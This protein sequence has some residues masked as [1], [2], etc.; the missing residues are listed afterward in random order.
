MTISTETKEMSGG[1][2]AGRKVVYLYCFADAARLK[3][4]EGTGIEGKNPL[5]LKQSNGIAAVCSMEKV[6][7]FMGPKGESNLLDIQ[8]V[9]SRACRHQ[10]VIEMAMKKSPVFPARFGTLFSSEKSMNHVLEVHHDTII[11]FL[12]K[13]ADKQ[14]W[15]I[16]GYLDLDNLI[17]EI[18]TELILN[19]EE[20]SEGLSQGKRY[21]RQKQKQAEARLKLEEWIKES[22]LSI[23]GSL[24]AIAA[25]LSEREIISRKASGKDLDMVLNW[26]ALIQENAVQTFWAE[27]DRI[28]AHKRFKGLSLELSGPWPPYSF[29]PRLDMM[30]LA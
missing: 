26:A 9:G 7:D 21:L 8:W 15:S 2:D 10:A 29:R 18:T 4:I 23:A 3:A 17:E 22:R 6:S 5:T 24:E 12:I 1:A 30:N 27:V 19:S 25:E 20:N 14:E 16:K 28:N 11:Q 13:T